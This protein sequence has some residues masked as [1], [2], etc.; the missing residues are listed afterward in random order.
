MSKQNSKEKATKRKLQREDILHLE[1]INYKIIILGIIVIVLGYIAL[2][3][4]PWD[5]FWSLTAAPIILV[6]GYCV[7]IP[8]GIMYKRKKNDTQ[9]KSTLAN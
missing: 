4:S 6:I 9:A 2:S 3:T 1:P 8:V 7:I 5:G